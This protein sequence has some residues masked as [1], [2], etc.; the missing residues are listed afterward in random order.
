MKCASNPILFSFVIISGGGEPCT[1]SG[2]GTCNLYTRAQDVCMYAHACFKLVAM[3][4]PTGFSELNDERRDCSARLQLGRRHNPPIERA[5]HTLLPFPLP[6][7]SRQPEALRNPISQRIL[8]LHGDT[9]PPNSPSPL[10]SAVAAEK[11]D[12]QG[13]ESPE[14]EFH[15]FRPVLRALTPL[16]SQD[17]PALVVI[18]ADEAN[19]GQLLSIPRNSI[20]TRNSGPR[21]STAAV[22]DWFGALVTHH[23]RSLRTEIEPRVMANPPLPD[24]ILLYHQLKGEE[25]D[26]LLCTMGLETV[27]LCRRGLSGSHLFKVINSRRGALIHQC[28]VPPFI[29]L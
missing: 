16:E 4:Q 8:L 27:E 9:T 25:V 29:A 19:L 22:K 14:P 1:G 3:I 18:L 26:G 7:Q 13:S 17:D 15:I 24:N 12:H 6:L 11:A 2:P 21:P 23:A 28:S 5:T 10:T 20:P